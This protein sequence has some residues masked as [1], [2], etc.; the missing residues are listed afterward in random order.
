MDFTWRSRRCTRDSL[1]QARQPGREAARSCKGR[2]SQTLPPLLHRFQIKHAMRKLPASVLVH[3]QSRASVR[4]ALRGSCL[5][6][7]LPPPRAPYPS[8]WC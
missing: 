7:D 2:S 6:G 5:G 1:T 3:C 8:W 4:R